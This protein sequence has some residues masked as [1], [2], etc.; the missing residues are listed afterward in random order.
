MKNLFL[1]ICL[2]IFFSACNKSN[3]FN[4]AKGVWLFTDINDKTEQNSQLTSYGDIE[5]VTL[6]GS[7]NSESK[8][9]N[10]DGSVV[11]LRN[12]WFD[13]GLGINEELNLTGKNI[14]ILARVKADTING[15]TPILNK[16]GNDQNIAYAIAF[17]QTE[18][19]DV[20]IEAKIGSDDI[21]GA[22]LLKYKIPKEKILDWQDIIFRF[23]GSKS[24]L[25]VN[26][27]L[28]DD[29]VTV[30]DIRDWNRRPFLIGAQYK[31]PYGYNESKDEYVESKLKGYIDHIILW[32]R[33]IS[34]EEIKKFSG[35]NELQ[36]ARPDYYN[37]KYRPQFHFTAKKNWLND[38]N[39]LVYYDGTYHLFFQ[40]MPPH[41][42]G[43]F[44]DW[45]HAVSKDLVHWEQ[46]PNHITPH[47][48]WGGCW[49]GSAVVDVNNDAGFQV[50]DKKTIIAFITSGGGQGS[51]LGPLNTQC[52]AYSTD[53]GFTFNYYD[54]NPVIY[55]IYA[56]NRDPKVTWDEASKKWIMSLYMDKGY[57]FG[58]FS[59]SDLKEWKYLSTIS[60][61]GVA[62]CPGF[63]PLPVDG[64]SSN[65]KW[66][67]FGANGNYMIGSFDGANFE[68]E[69]EVIRMDYGNNF[70][71]GQ[72]WDNAPDGR[73]VLIAWM[74]TKRYPG[75]PFEQQMNFPTELT[76]RNTPDGVR[77][78]RNPV[79]EIANLYENNYSWKDTLLTAGENLFKELNGDLFDINIEVD[80]SNSSSFIINLRGVRIYY[81]I[82]KKKII[83][84]GPVIENNIVPDIWKSESEPKSDYLNKLGEAPLSPIE[85]KIKLRI[86]VDRTS[87]EV[88]GNDG[89][90]VITSCFMP[91][92]E[93]VYSFISEN[94]TKIISSD[95]YS[96]KSAWNLER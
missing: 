36:D 77:V 84:E 66:L 75:M 19:K 80:Y 6:K 61:P 59:S 62:E 74:P 46:I 94:K 1:I 28:C 16:A 25:Y 92:D 35:V 72:T 88:F 32:E 71:A 22:H 49:S 11:Y 64:D 58:L 69:T 14:S 54:Q 27:A 39:G 43:A 26:G 12:G 81:D 82:E 53:G 17:N 3:S 55:N 15:Y 44:K 34:D 24:E 20:F 83:C 37:E 73:C 9:R 23:N 76:L 87:I 41:R 89:Q 93:K 70:F 52:I 86:L 8:R 57:D 79:P 33:F 21:A 30:G 95:V 2:F 13:A 10:G 67:L 68:P 47:K 60:L 7:E 50:G 78:F 31:K 38:P 96:L 29:E 51:G 48:V 4:N 91:D 63:E 85:G 40:Y 65:Q 5:F 90:I 18:E 45:G 42:P 56:A